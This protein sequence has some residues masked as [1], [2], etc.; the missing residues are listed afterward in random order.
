MR[1]GKPHHKQK[2]N[3]LEQ[4]CVNITYHCISEPPE[5]IHLN[6]HDTGIDDEE[7]T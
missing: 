3:P 7:H 5:Q 1:G 6:T 2:P 4:D